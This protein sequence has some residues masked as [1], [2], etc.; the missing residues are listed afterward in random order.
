MTADE[1]RDHFSEAYE[2]ELTGDTKVAFEAALAGD[3][4]LS[5]EYD[6][7]ADMLR[8][9]EQHVGPVG[10]TP[11]ILRGVQKRL[12]GGA[13]SRFY[14]DRLSRIFGRGGI[15]PILLGMCIV[16]L[17]GLLWLTMDYLQ[18]LPANHGEPPASGA[19]LQR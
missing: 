13:G 5:S 10:P 19:P 15:N 17:V 6:A 14:S 2:G 11:D 4:A 7:F 16:A 8:S 1:A 9:A 3:P 18:R 12:R